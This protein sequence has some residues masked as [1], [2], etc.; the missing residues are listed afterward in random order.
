MPLSS[1]SHNYSYRLFSTLALFYWRVN[2]FFIRSVNRILFLQVSLGLLHGR[3]SHI[4][5]PP[6]R[7]Q[8]IRPCVPPDRR[9]L[10]NW[11]GSTEDDS[12]DDNNNKWPFGQLHN[13]TDFY[14][15]DRLSDCDGWK[16]LS[17]RCVHGVFFLKMWDEWE[18]IGLWIDV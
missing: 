14:M 8:R 10:L 5:W 1:V 13:N 16:C 7:W 4:I 2:F 6:N 9:P 11:G 12:N 17:C 3:A 18:N 15:Q